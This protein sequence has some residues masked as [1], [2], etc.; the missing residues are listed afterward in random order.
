MAKDNSF[1]LRS[2][3][4]LSVEHSYNA[5]PLL[6]LFLSFSREGG[7]EEEEREREKER[8]LINDRFKRA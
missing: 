6:S 5:E 2:I 3:C 4:R 8:V 1:Y 7:G